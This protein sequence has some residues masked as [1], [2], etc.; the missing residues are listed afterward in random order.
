MQQS[1]KEPPGPSKTTSIKPPTLHV[2]ISEAK[3]E[4]RFSTLACDNDDDDYDEPLQ[5]FR[6]T[7][8]DPDD[9]DDDDPDSAP[10]GG[11]INVVN[12]VDD[13]P[14]AAH[15]TD[16]VNDFDMT[17][18]K[19][20]V[21][22]V[23]AILEA[24][25]AQL[26]QRTPEMLAR[27]R[28]PHLAY[29]SIDLLLH[30]P[31]FTIILRDPDYSIVRF[32]TGIIASCLTPN[33]D[34]ARAHFLS[35]ARPA[36]PPPRRRATPRYLPEPPPREPDDL[37][38][39]D[40]T[41]DLSAPSAF[42]SSSASVPPR[43]TKPRSPPTPLSLPSLASASPPEWGNAP[44]YAPAIAPAPW[45]AFAVRGATTLASSAP[46]SNLNLGVPDARPPAL[47]LSPTPTM[48]S[49]TMTKTALTCSS[50]CRPCPP[51]RGERP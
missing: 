23:T 39:S 11:H 20:P 16:D 5:H 22:H 44:L 36:L 32:P 30:D 28:Y 43:P 50:T 12:D 21:T 42:Q 41:Y 40:I 7:M 15:L 27:A 45:Q 29:A 35:P 25:D 1:K 37:L 38:Q 26:R 46:N 51:S 17:G 10:H 47:P 19:G 13:M 33:L 48:N 6:A 24:V 14:D 4:Q 31:F 2:K 34:R 8:T 18:L 9:D 49:L 3:P